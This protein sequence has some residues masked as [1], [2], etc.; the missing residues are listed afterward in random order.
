M[1]SVS[2]DYSKR[3]SD[4]LKCY[5]YVAKRVVAIIQNEQKLSSAAKNST[6]V[7]WKK[8]VMGLFKNTDESR[9]MQ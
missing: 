6:R 9:M 1:T 8:T 4:V 2:L 5:V 3:S 7:F